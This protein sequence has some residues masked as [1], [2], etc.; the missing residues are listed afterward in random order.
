MS[1]TVI[2]EMSLDEV[3]AKYEKFLRFMIKKYINFENSR[4]TYEDLYQEACLALIDAYNRYDPGKGEFSTY[5]G[6]Y[7]YGRVLQ[8]MNRNLSP[9][10]FRYRND[11]VIPD[12]FELINIDCYYDDS[13]GSKRNSLYADIF[14]KE[15]DNLKTAELI[16]VGKRI[17]KDDRDYRIWY[18]IYILGETQVDVARD[19]GISKNRVNQILSKMNVK[20]GAIYFKDEAQYIAE[21]RKRKQDIV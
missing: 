18:R 14:G 7:V 15:D 2:T 13:E 16:N 12:K 20:F 1:K 3:Y 11:G 19:E 6:K 10:S 8:Y 5:L 21:K 4:Y 9:L 17:A